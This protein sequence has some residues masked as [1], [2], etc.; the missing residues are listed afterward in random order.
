MSDRRGWF[1]DI[2][3]EAPTSDYP[4]QPFLETGTGFIP[5]IAVWFRTQAACEDWIR[6]MVLGVGIIEEEVKGA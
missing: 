3:D 6:R 5:G 1:A 4:W 2:S